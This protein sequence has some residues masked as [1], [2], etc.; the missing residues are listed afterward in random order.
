MVV[1]SNRE[2]K[3]KAG[4]GIVMNQDKAK[5]LSE[6]AGEAIMK[7]EFCSSHYLNYVSVIS[8]KNEEYAKREKG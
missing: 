4:V 2:G 5:M 8:H 1:R 7:R 3:S 6:N